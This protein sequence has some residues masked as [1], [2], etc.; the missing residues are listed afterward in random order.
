MTNKIDAITIRVIRSHLV[1]VA[2]EMGVT[3]RQTAYSKIFNEGSDSSCGVF[4]HTGRLWAQGEFLP[5]H[6]GALQFAVREAIEK[7]DAVLL[8]DP[9]H[10]GTHL[11][12][13]TAITSIFYA[14]EIVAF[15]ANR[16]HHADIGGTV[17]GSFNSK[18]TE[19]FQEGLRIPP[20]RCALNR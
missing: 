12:D 15:A 2:R 9:Y 5:I 16:A 4:D 10:R 8:H 17:S 3:L 13:L 1:S 19:N 20:M 11:P 6:R 18:A 14:C 7:G